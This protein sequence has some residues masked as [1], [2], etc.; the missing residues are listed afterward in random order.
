MG[1]NFGPVALDPGQALGARLGMSGAA[2]IDPGFCERGGDVAARALACG[3]GAV[4]LLAV[5]GALCAG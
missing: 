3:G 5:V 4:H 1:G 2:A